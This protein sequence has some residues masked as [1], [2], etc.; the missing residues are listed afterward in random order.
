MVVKI[1]KNFKRNF[2][3]FSKWRFVHFC[4]QGHKS[5]WCICNSYSMLKKKLFWTFFTIHVFL[6]YWL[7][8]LFTNKFLFHFFFLQKR[9]T[10]SIP[11]QRTI[12]I[13]LKKNKEHEFSDYVRT[14]KASPNIP[15]KADQTPKVPVLKPSPSPIL[16]KGPLLRKRLQNVAAVSTSLELNH[17]KNRHIAADYF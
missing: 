2:Q 9:L 15:F 1:L 5:M 13:N 8:C 10:A 14:I 4:L 16:V 11:K 6:A 7:I 12:S 3:L 17:K